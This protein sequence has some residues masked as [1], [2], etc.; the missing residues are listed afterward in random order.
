MFSK[1]CFS[2]L[3]RAT[4]TIEKKDLSR[5]TTVRNFIFY[6]KSWYENG[7]KSYKI[8][9]KNGL[10]DGL[11]QRWHENGQKFIKRTW[12]NG[13]LEGLEQQWYTNGHKKCSIVISKMNSKRGWISGG[14]KMDKNGLNVFGKTDS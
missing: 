3:V 7:Q 4:T 5:T 2:L 11:E 13:K 9:R 10:K 1:D 14:T 8:V 12:K 6:E